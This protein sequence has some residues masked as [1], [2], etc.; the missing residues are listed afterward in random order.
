[1]TR[2]SMAI[3]ATTTTTTSSKIDDDMVPI[4][5]ST[6]PNWREDGPIRIE[7][8]EETNFPLDVNRKHQIP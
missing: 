6:L 3:C 5:V 2:F 7:I 8:D 4:L 1:M